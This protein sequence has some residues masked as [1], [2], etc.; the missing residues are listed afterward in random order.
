MSVSE[1]G[2]G[3]GGGER[4]RERERESTKRNLLLLRSWLYL[5]GSPF[6]VIFLRM[7]LF[8][9]KKKNPTM[10]VVRFR[11]RNWC[12]LGVFLLPAFNC[13]GHECQGLLSPWDGTHV[14][15]LDL[16]L[17]SHPKEF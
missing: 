16:G 13:L 7:T 5:W 11:L 8:K 1:G 9:K 15:R 14:C 4:E 10:E 6:W 2:G 17:Y 12:M 3:G